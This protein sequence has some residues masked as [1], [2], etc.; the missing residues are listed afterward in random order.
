MPELIRFWILSPNW[1]DLIGFQVEKIGLIYNYPGFDSERINGGEPLSFLFSLPSLPTVSISSYKIT[2]CSLWAPFALHHVAPARKITF[3]TLQSNRFCLNGAD[4]KLDFL[5]PW[6]PFSCLLDCDR[7]LHSV[8]PDHL[9]NSNRLL[10]W[11]C[12]QQWWPKQRHSNVT[13]NPRPSKTAH[14]I[15]PCYCYV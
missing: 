15:C 9:S 2:R 12:S 13:T 11:Q 3:A 10:L 7:A 4:R 8:C 6:E 14:Y 1:T 5:Y